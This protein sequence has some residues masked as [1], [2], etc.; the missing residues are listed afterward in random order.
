MR[1]S[2]MSAHRLIK[3]IKYTIANMKHDS[4]ST[5]PESPD[6]VLKDAKSNTYCVTQNHKA[7][8]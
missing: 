1:H 8:K 3:V 5:C 2:C 4:Q 7:D 6:S